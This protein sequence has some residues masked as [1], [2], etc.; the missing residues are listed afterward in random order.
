MSK[1]KVSD[2]FKMKITPIPSNTDSMNAKSIMIQKIE[3]KI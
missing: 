2:G 3:V 1:I